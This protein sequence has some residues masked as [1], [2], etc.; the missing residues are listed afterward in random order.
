M[1]NACLH[2]RSPREA[3]SWLATREIHRNQVTFPFR[4]NE[5]ARQA[6]DV[7]DGASDRAAKTRH[8]LGTQGDLAIAEVMHAK[9]SVWFNPR[10]SA[11]RHDACGAFCRCAPED[12]SGGPVETESLVR[13]AHD[14]AIPA[15]ERSA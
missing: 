7:D 11:G 15:E 14:Q 10:D 3:P 13:R 5:Q 9:Q 2:V 6:L 12:A 8:Q 1:R 4:Y